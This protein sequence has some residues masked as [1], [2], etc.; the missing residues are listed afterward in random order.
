MQPDSLTQGFVIYSREMEQLVRLRMSSGCLSKLKQ[1][2]RGVDLLL[3]LDDS[4]E[5]ILTLTPQNAELLL[6]P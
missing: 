1:L 6:R 2:H 4:G 5:V 3:T